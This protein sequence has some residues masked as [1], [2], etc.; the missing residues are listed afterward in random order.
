V[1]IKKLKRIPDPLHLPEGYESLPVPLLLYRSEDGAILPNPAF[2]ERF[3]K[4]AV[5]RI[6]SA[7]PIGLARERPVH[8]RV[9]EL[10]GR[11]EGFLME[12]DE[13]LQVPVDLKVSSHGSAA[14][15][16][17]LVLFEDTS[18]RSNLQKQLLERHL[19]LEGSYRKLQ[20]LQDALIQSAKLASLGELSSGIAHELNQPLQAIMGF[21]QELKF[22]ERLSPTGAEFL[23]DIIQAS[24]KMAEIIKSLRTFAREA[25]QDLHATSVAHAIEESTRLLRHQLMQSAVNLEIQIEPELPLTRANPIQLEQVFVNL[26][27]NARDALESSDRKDRTLRIEA[28][29]TGTEIEVRV[30]DN[31][32]GM[33]PEVQERIF[34]PFFTTKPIGKGTGL[35]LSITHGILARAGARIRVESVPG[36]GTCFTIHFPYEHSQTK[37]ET[38]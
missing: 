34:D 25:G 3:G 11:Q 9:L 19:E 13:H 17:W 37:G 38:A 31:G 32:C 36:A 6:L 28:R 8:P 20:N 15:S 27:G 30:S 24:K 2:E 26:I 29:N 16:V 10:A 18:V 5:D 1:A 33:P 4:G 21:S 14:G 23:D 7:K 35:G 22:V 12:T